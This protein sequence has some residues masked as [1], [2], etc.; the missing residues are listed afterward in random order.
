MMDRRRQYTDA[1]GVQLTHTDNTLLHISGAFP[2][3]L[4]L[5]TLEL[6]TENNPILKKNNLSYITKKFLRSHGV[7][8]QVIQKRCISQNNAMKPVFLHFK[9]TWLPRARASWCPKMSHYTALLSGSFCSFGCSC[10]A[11]KPARK[12]Q[13]PPPSF[14]E[15]LNVKRENSFSVTQR[16]TRSLCFISILKIWLQFSANLY[17]WPDYCNIQSLTVVQWAPTSSF[18]KSVFFFFSF[19]FDIAINII[20]WRLWNCFLPT[21]LKQLVRQRRWL[22][23]ASNTSAG[24]SGCV[25]WHERLHSNSAGTNSSHC[26][27]PCGYWIPAFL[28]F[29]PFPTS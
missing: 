18:F 19:F 29:S 10:N 21:I 13:H 15:W 24:L 9:V 16:N 20:Q 3:T 4:K 23:V 1:A 11:N 12:S 2:I 27:S 17:W 28:N 5:C 8:F 25:L 22:T 7:V 14:L 26:K 6:W